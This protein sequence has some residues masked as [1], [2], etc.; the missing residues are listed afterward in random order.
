MYKEEHITSRSNISAPCATLSPTQKSFV[1]QDL[2]VTT[3]NPKQ[4]S[5][6]WKT[7]AASLPSEDAYTRTPGD[8]MSQYIRNTSNISAT[9]TANMISCAGARPKNLKPEHGKQLQAVALPADITN[10]QR[11]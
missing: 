6:V 5:R 2:R 4:K 10:T 9:F 7:Q 1:I 11:H 8:R 3:Q